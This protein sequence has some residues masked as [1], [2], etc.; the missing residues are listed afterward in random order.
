MFCLC[1]VG[2]TVSHTAA[3]FDWWIQVYAVSTNVSNKVSLQTWYYWT[4]V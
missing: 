4:A 2:A 3:R 1:T